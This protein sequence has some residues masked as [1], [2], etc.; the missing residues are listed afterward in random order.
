MT[1]VRLQPSHRR[2]KFFLLLVGAVF[3]L[4]VFLVL[5]FL[6][7]PVPEGRLTVVLLGDPVEIASY[8]PRL[9]R[10]AVVQMTK[11]AHISGV[12]GLGEYSLEAL[13]TLGQS[14]ASPSMFLRESLAEELGVPVPYVIGY[15]QDTFRNWEGTTVSPSILSWFQLPFFLQG[16]FVSNLTLQ[17]FVMLIRLT[18]S[19]TPANTQRYILR[20]NSGLVEQKAKDGASYLRFDRS[21]FDTRTADIFE[22]SLLREEAVRV[23]VYNTTDRPAVGARVGRMIDKLGAFVVSVA[24]DNSSSVQSCEISGT[25]EKLQTKTS[26]RIQAI[27]GCLPREDQSQ[28]QGD[29]YVRVGNEFANRYILDAK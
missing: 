18:Q 29:L 3:F 14:E 2:M 15:K 4:I 9:G 24:N 11:D 25:V 6:M 19:Q 17:E 7:R 16:R 8:E 23:V 27:F 12:F 10:W 22:E 20:E 13:W 28:G 5:L 1:R 26:Q 21:A